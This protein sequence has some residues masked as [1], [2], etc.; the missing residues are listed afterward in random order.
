MTGIFDTVQRQIRRDG[1]IG[2]DEYMVLALFDGEAGYYQTRKTVGRDFITAPGVSQI[3]GEMIGAWVADI[4]LRAD[5]PSPFALVEL[6]PGEGEM[7][8]DM[9]RTASHV[10]GFADAARPVLMEVSEHLRKVQQEKLRGR[11]ATWGSSPADAPRMPSIYVANE[12]FDAL[13]VRQFVRRESAWRERRIAIDAV[14]RF[15]FVEGASQ[16]LPCP[17]LAQSL[18]RAKDGAIA[19]YCEAAA[20]WIQAIADRL[21]AYGGI[22]LV[23]DYG[24]EER[25]LGEAGGGDTWQGLRNGRQ[26]DPLCHVGETD[27]SAHVN[28]SVLQR[29]ASSR[30]AEATPVMKQGAFLEGLGIAARAATLAYGKH[31]ETREAI[32]IAHRRLTAA[33]EMGSLF[34]VLAFR[35]PGWPSPEGFQCRPS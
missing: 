26:T 13:P 7:M 24:Y 3:Y 8:E 25:E 19:E 18:A 33:S 6:G 4:W 14:G 20:S 34:R 10:D 9:L 35:A 15:V 22:A 30:G 11:G 31:P 1:S 12:F 29:I 28:F 27:L 16:E 23:V 17:A 5:R 2:V 32:A 21:V